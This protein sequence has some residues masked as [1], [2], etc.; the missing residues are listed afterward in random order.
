[1]KRIKSGI[2]GLDPIVDGGIIKNSVSIVYGCAGIGKTTFASQFLRRGLEN[3]Y[4]GIY[5]TMEEDKD[6]ILKGAEEM[7]WDEI[8]DFVDSELLI[9]IEA[10]GKDFSEFIRTELATFV[11][12]WEG[13]SDARIVIDPLTPIMWALDSKY[14]QRETVSFLF[15][16]MKKIGTV[17]CTLE[18]HASSD[19]YL[20]EDAIIPTYLSDTVIH[21]NRSF[22]SSSK[23]KLNVLKCRNSWHSEESHTYQIIKGMG[24]VISPKEKPHKKVAQIQKKSKDDL[25]KKLRTQPKKI[26]ER[27]NKTISCLSESDIH[28]FTPTQLISMILQEYEIE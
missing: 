9:F 16:Q 11:A 17:V 7:G 13:G 10:R 21:I 28:D 6:Q 26:K 3:G 4:E 25:K 5:I 15:K 12:K 14:E 27:V 22:S 8:Y 1:M 23:K 20:T 24:I 19:N 18:E 2:Y